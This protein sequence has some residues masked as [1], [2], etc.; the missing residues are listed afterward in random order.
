MEMVPFPNQFSERVPF[1]F[2]RQYGMGLKSRVSIKIN[3]PVGSTRVHS[4]DDWNGPVDD[5]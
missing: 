4:G 3:E 5:L 2:V 1:P